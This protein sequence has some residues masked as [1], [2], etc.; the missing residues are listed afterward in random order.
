ME[1]TNNIVH[2]VSFATIKDDNKINYLCVGKIEG[3]CR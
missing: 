1:S 3:L 2:F